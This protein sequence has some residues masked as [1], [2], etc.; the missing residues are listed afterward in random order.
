MSPL[1]SDELISVVMPV[2]NAMPH[3]DAA[4]QSILSQTHRNLEFVIFDDGSTDGSSERLR[5]WAG[6]DDR[7]RLF[8]SPT[9]LGPAG[10]SN[11]VIA[12][13]KAPLI[14]RMDADDVSHPER[15]ARQ[16][17][18]LRQQPDLCLVATACDLIGADGKQFRGPDVWRLARRSWFAPFAHGSALFRRSAFDAVGGYREQCAFWEDQDL[19]VRLLAFSEGRIMTIPDTL[20]SVRYAPVS[21]RI[22]SDQERVEAAIDLMYRSVDRL[23][24]GEWYEDLLSHDAPAR[25]LDP[26]VFIASGSLDLWSNGRPRL[27]R[28]FLKRARLAPDFRSVSTG[29]WTAWAS[30]SPGSLRLFLRLLVW[31]RNGFAHGKVHGDAPIAWKPPTRLKWLP[32]P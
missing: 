18:L 22:A 5:E 27:F 10:S 26:R 14:A 19:F 4:V 6:K 20:Y 24:R 28:R 21:T 1:P 31:I 32:R 8:E 30:A 29:V 2:H 3:L 25:K 13:S 23:D 12:H 17:E 7:I 11:R 9:K 16:L 15:L